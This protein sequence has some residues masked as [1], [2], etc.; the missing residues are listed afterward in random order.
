M[1]GLR[2]SLVGAGSVGCS[3]AAWIGACGGAL[4][5]VAGRAG[6]RGT[7]AGAR[8]LGVPP[9]DARN[10]SS[11]GEDLLLIAVPDD[12][13]SGVAEALAGRPQAGVALHVSGVAS[14]EV[15][16]PLR[17]GGTAIGGF[18]PLR[19]FPTREGAIAAAAGVF[20]ALD[21]DPNAVALGRR[22]TL[23]FGGS[24]AVISG[25]ERPL[26]H[27]VATMMAGAVTTVA[28][29]AM[30]IAG[31]SGLPAEV[32]PGFAGLAIDALA[33]A[34][35]LADPAAGITGPAARGD[36]ATFLLELAELERIAP[37]AVPIVVALGRES[38]RQRA[39]LATPDPP[40]QA[41]ADLLARAELLDLT[42]DRVLTSPSKPSG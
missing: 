11:G 32:R 38:L 23:S 41:L 16:A 7:E 33:K 9:T 20:F 40:R 22:L 5:Q 39:R 35:A 12:A 6:S 13:L 34:L 26:Y 27:L 2:F 36:Q 4:Q 42:K 31:R 21:G 19:A 17:S 3:L 15:L 29:L 25:G 8:W 10:F 18:H 1:T 14:A 28:A 37:E 30:E 24:A